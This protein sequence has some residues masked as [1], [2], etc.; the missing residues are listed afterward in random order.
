MGKNK[1]NRK[2]LRGLERQIAHHN[3]KIAEEMKRHN[4]DEGLI[5]HWQSEV[6]SWTVR[7]TRL[8]RRLPGGQ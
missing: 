3:E 2:I 7:V 8:K 1:E 6:R 5:R 4:S